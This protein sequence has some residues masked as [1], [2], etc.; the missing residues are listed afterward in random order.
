MI[1]RSEAVR[2]FRKVPGSGAA[3]ANS[4]TGQRV[5]REHTMKAW[6]V[7]GGAACIMTLWGQLDQTA[8]LCAALSPGV[9][10]V[11]AAVVVPW[12]ALYDGVLSGVAPIWTITCYLRLVLHTY[13]WAQLAREGGPCW[14]LQVPAGMI[15][16]LTAWCAMLPLL[17]G[18]HTNVWR[19]GRLISVVTGTLQLIRVGLQALLG[20]MASQ[21]SLESHSWLEACGAETAY[22]PSGIPLWAAACWGISWLISGLLLGPANRYALSRA[23]GVLTPAGALQVSLSDVS[24]KDRLDV[25]LESDRLYRRPYG[26]PSTA[27]NATVC[28]S[29]STYSQPGAWG[30]VAAAASSRT[31][32]SGSDAKSRVD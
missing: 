2:V 21:R 24:G 27:G 5:W 12:P 7:A 13:Q 18:Q 28:S 3:M 8:V 14:R 9:M 23:A 25:L 20:S 4:E 30:A 31:G 22:A 11:L 29:R 26:P 17:N 6:A 1:D 15:M 16:V 19:A 32:S 10:I